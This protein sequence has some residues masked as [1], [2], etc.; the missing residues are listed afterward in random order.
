MLRQTWEHYS[1]IRNC[2]GPHTGIPNVKYT[3]ASPESE[4]VSKEKLGQI[5]Y[6]QPWMVNTVMSS[7]PYLA[8]RAAIQKTLEE[9]KG[10]IDNAVSK[11]LDAEDQSSAS[12]SQGSSSVERDADSEDEDVVSMARKKQDRRLSRA[13]RIVLEKKE[14]QR[15]KHELAIRMKERALPSTKESSSTP[16]P[17]SLKAIEAHD[18]DETEE[19]D[20]Q[21]TSPYKGSTATSISTSSSD[22][23]TAGKARLGGVRLKLSQP[24]Q[25]DNIID[26][27]LDSPTLETSGL[28]NAAPESPMAKS[29]AHDNGGSGDND[30]TS[31]WK[32]TPSPKRLTARDKHD[33]KKAAQKSAAKERKKGVA[34]VVKKSKK[35]APTPFASQKAKEYSPSIETHIKVLYI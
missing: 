32:P 16:E 13:T 9:C 29:A 7:L 20:W 22:N 6:V 1:S 27:T 15:R 31:E 25:P 4:K 18:T 23:T 2:A 28:E 10:S 34:Y 14:E 5:P 3:H 30:K 26:L 19:E 8:D 24:K 35:D 33:L 21:N 17:E 12:A 11:L